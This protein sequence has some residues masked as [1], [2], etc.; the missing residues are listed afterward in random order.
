MSYSFGFILL[1][2]LIDY[3]L[4]YSWIKSSYN[5]VISF[6][7]CIKLQ[8]VRNLIFSMHKIVRGAFPQSL[9]CFLSIHD[10]FRV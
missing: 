3:V 10:E 9:E 7:Q 6:L 8:E 2:A 1:L 4:I 5:I